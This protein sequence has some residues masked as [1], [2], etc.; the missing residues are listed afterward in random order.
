MP[1][2]YINEIDNTVAGSVAENTNVVYI[3]GVIESNGTL[4]TG[5]P[6]LF[7]TTSAFLT[8]VTGSDK[9]TLSDT[10]LNAIMA[11]SLITLGM[12]VL[13]ESFGKS[14]ASGTPADSAAIAAS[15]DWAKLKDRGL[16]RVKFLTCGATTAL[17]TPSGKTE[18]IAKSMLDCAGAR[19]DCIALLDH[20]QTIT[21]TAGS[22]IS[23]T[24]YSAFSAAA[25]EANAKYGAAF[26]P[27]CKFNLGSTGTLTLPGSF[28]FLSAY[29]RSVKNNPNWYA[30]AGFMRG[31][32]PSISEPIYKYGDADSAVLQCRDINGDGSFGSSDNLGYAI[33]PISEIDTAGYIVWGNRTLLDNKTAGGL[34]GSSFLNVRNLCCDV[35][36]TLYRAARKYTFEQNNDILVVNFNSE[37]TPLLDRDL[38]GNG[39]RGYKLIPQATNIKGRLKEIIK[40]IPIEA[41]EDF[42]LTV[43]MTDSLETVSENA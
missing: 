42:D 29:A 1:H 13:F 36:K 27:W 20:A 2:I 14:G 32:I 22:T 43:E 30:A 5:E 8:A 12:P 9:G 41:V 23:E 4:T 15:V 33:N 6:T 34:T 21:P 16:Y 19:G 37:L 31:Q 18:S 39:I 24:V 11:K 26:S 3:P 28:A 7:S 10:N 17:V 38:S 25:S 40:I 35:K